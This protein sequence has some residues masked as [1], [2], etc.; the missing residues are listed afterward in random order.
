MDEKRSDKLTESDR[1]R[2]TLEAVSLPRSGMVP[3]W[4]S[5][6]SWGSVFAGAFVAAAVALL[7]GAV[8]LWADF[9]LGRITTVAAIKS[10]ATVTSIWVGFSAL[11]ALFIGG[12]VAARLSDSIETRSGLWHG[13]VTWAVGLIAFLGMTLVGFPGLLGFGLTSHSVLRVLPG[14]TAGISL[15]RATAATA[16]Y[17]AWFVVFAVLTLVGALGGGWVGSSLLARRA[18][19]AVTGAGADVS[20]AAGATEEV[21]ERRAA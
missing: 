11:I 6:L 16:T 4:L 1:S 20:T 7:L 3:A 15:T 5:R 2:P 14:S 21:P 18:A 13:L 12:I 10:E 9:G 17:S 8:S 19:P